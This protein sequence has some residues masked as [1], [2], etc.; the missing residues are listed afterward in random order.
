MNILLIVPRYDFSN[1]PNYNYYFPM[2]LGYISAVLKKNNYN[3]DCLNLNYHNGTT[4]QILTKKLNSKKYDLICTGHMGIGYS[5][6]EKIINITKKHSSKPKFILG[7]ALITTESKL[8]FESLKPDFAVLGEGELTIIE[9][10][11]AIE[12]IIL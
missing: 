12:K 9:L 8:I 10:L 2:G 11:K 6:I 1:K 3:L 5:I 7:G 4:E